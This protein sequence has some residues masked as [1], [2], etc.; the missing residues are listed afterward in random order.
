MS[1]L[2]IYYVVIWATFNTIQTLEVRRK[3]NNN[4]DRNNIFNKLSQKRQ[5]SCTIF[6]NAYTP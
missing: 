5:P 6:F 1:E 3:K 2:L 4:Y